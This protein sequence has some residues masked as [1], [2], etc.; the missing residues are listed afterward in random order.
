M[1]YVCI[2][3]HNKPLGKISKCSK[4]LMRKDLKIMQNPTTKR[5]ILALSH[6]ILLLWIFIL[7]ELVP[8]FKIVYPVALKT[9]QIICMFSHHWDYQIFCW[10]TSVRKYKNKSISRDLINPWQ[11]SGPISVAER[12]SAHM[13]LLVW[14]AISQRH[15]IIFFFPGLQLT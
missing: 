7:L 4:M 5:I 15:C 1:P 12:K 13:S 9:W 10:G 8:A 6:V 3:V 11:S 14:S 2:S